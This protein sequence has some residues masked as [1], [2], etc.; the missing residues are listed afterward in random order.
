MVQKALDIKPSLVQVQIMIIT[1]RCS[2][3]LAQ[4]M[5]V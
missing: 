1:G 5:Q 3:Q 2:C 4:V